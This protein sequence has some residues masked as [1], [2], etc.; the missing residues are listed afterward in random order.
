M[1]EE[2]AEDGAE[3]GRLLDTEEAARRLGIS[4]RTVQT[5]VRQRRIP[6]VKMGTLTR[7]R[8]AALEAWI[9]SQEVKAVG[10]TKG[11]SQDEGEIT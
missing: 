11:S 8:P 1:T 9:Q 2:H 5:W 6:F 3:L 10:K 7:F 4:P